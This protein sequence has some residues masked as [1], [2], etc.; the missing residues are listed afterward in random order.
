MDLFEY[1]NVIFDK[2]KF[3]KVEDSEKKK[4]YFMLLRFFSIKYPV[5][6]SQLSLVPYNIGT[7][8]IHS[9]LSRSYTGRLPAWV[10]TKGNSSKEDK[11]D[12]LSSISKEAKDIYAQKLELDTKDTH[13]LLSSPT[14]EDIRK[15]KNIQSYLD[16]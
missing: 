9:V 8:I 14:D 6:A 1:R 7:K 5:E 2:E 15:I 4:H 13:F 16:K 10:F 11:K 12:P 3:S